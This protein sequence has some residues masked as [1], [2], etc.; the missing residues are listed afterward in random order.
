MLSLGRI[1]AL[2]GLLSWLLNAARGGEEFPYTAYVAVEGA[3]AVAGP[4]H[5]FYVT[6]RLGRA[7]KV[8]VYRE[9]AS[10]WLAI[11]PPAGSFSWVLAEVVAKVADQEHLGRVTEPTGS[12]IGTAIEKVSEHR[13]QVTLKEGEVVEILGERA[14]T[15][16]D[17]QKQTWL[18]IAP[19]AG[20]FR[21]IHLRDVSRQ[22][23]PAEDQPA[24]SG[25]ADSSLGQ[26]ARDAAAESP[27]T[28]SSEREPLNNSLKSRRESAVTL[29][30]IAPAGQRPVAN[31][32]TSQFASSKDAGDVGPVVGDGFVARRRR[33]GDQAPAALA[34]P[35][36]GPAALAA[37]PRSVAPRETLAGGVDGA[38]VVR[39]IEQ[40]ETDL[41]LMLSK[42]RSLW[43]LGPL[44][45]RAERLV[46]QGAEPISR[47]RARLVL[48][49][50]KQFE[51]AFDVANFGPI[52]QASEATTAGEPSQAA[53][54][55]GPTDPKYD[56][57]GWLKPV[58]SR[59]GDKPIAPFAVVD[60]DGKPVAFITP[61]A[62]LNLQSY[63]NKQVGVYGQRG[64]L[65]ELKRPHVT[66]QRV[67]DLN[68]QWR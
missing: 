40:I 32:A 19:P 16:A 3:E 47:G 26:A 12:W 44:K 62:G 27:A 63:L 51:G 4:G 13:Q 58:I 59:K 7:T 38:E 54:S 23:P 37:P 48:D 56:A 31:G 30:D 15:G 39:Q 28:E 10:G 41:S 36:V 45:Q 49:K 53:Q 52:R 46:E 21:W 29:H 18:K 67:I 57:R 42:D 61:T 64:Y 50:I 34:S 11:R 24:E 9:E 43:N 1:I 2:V 66:A 65:E 55:G 14:V 6:Q 5:R 68:R 22:R 17:G 35:V 25:P 20:E 33:A 60:E 8:E